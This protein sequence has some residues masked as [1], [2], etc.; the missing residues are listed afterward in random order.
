MDPQ[1][2]AI[3]NQLESV[4]APQRQTIE[5]QRPIAEQEAIAARAS[6]D[7]AKVNAFRD[8]GQ[9]ANRQGMFFSGFQPQEQASFVGTKYL[10]ALA[11]VESS[12]QQRKLNLEDQLNKLKGAQMQQAQSSYAAMI[13]E[14][15]RQREAELKRQQDMQ[16]AQMRIAA[17]RSSTAK[18]PANTGKGYSM[19]QK[20]GNAGYFFTGPNKN[21]VSMY[22]F[23]SATGASMLDLMR[24]SPSKYDRNA[25][26]YANELVNAGRSEDQVIRTLQANFPKLF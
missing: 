6:L 16:I 19:G 22:Q 5:A 14:Q 13:A 24:N 12:L 18:Q 3:Y 11:G 7:Q 26:T 1:L 2:Q 25:Y 9:Q 20:A 8:I 15:N 10:P 17:S 23:A 4:Y 21:P